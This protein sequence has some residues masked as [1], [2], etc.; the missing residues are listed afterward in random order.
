MKII[1]IGDIHGRDTW[2]KIIQK[3]TFDKLIFIGDYFDLKDDIQ[4][5]TQISNFLEILNF[6]KSV[7]PTH[8]VVL[9]FGN[10]DFHYLPGINEN[11]SGFNEIARLQIGQILSDCIAERQFNMIYNQ[12]NFLFSHAGV[13]KTWLY[14]NIWVNE[15]LDPNGL[16]EAV[17]DLFYFKPNKFKFTIGKNQSMYGDDVTQ[18]PIWVRP[19]SLLKDGLSDYFQVVGHT[20]KDH[21]KQILPTENNKNFKGLAF[22]DALHSGEY[23]IIED[24]KISVGKV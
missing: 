23:L 5:N 6:K 7:E 14:N 12:G 13:T 19:K 1:A 20:A 10:H 9:L 3:E 21:I 18:S 4:S 16:C 8:E 2:K 17:N 15:N 11:Y 24:N 22:I